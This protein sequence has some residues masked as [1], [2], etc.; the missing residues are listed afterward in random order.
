MKRWIR[1]A[2][3]LF[4]LCF[5]GSAMS[6]D[7][8][9]LAV[10]CGMEETESGSRVKAGDATICP[11][12]VSFQG[13]YIL[14][15]EVLQ[16]PLFE[17][18]AGF[19]VDDATLKSEFTL[20]ASEQIGISS[21]L[22]FVLSSISMLLWPVFG[23]VLAYKAWPYVKQIND[24]GKLAFSDNK[25]DTVRFVSY[26]TFLLVL[27]MPAGMSG[28]KNGEGYPITLGQGAAVVAALP[29]FMGGNY[30]FSTNLAAL[31]TASSDVKIN[32]AS[33]LPE[34]QAMANTMIETQLCQARTRQALMTINGKSGSEFFKDTR[35]SILF[36]GTDQDQDDI[37]K[38]Y[39]LCLGYAGIGEEE[40]ELDGLREMTINKRAP[41]APDCGH[42][43]VFSYR[44]EYKPEQHGYAH[45]C[46]KISFDMDLNKFATTLEKD[47][48]EDSLEGVLE[49]VKAVDYYRRF[50]SAFLPELRTV[51]NDT[52]LSPEKRFAEIGAAVEKASS[53][54]VRQAFAQFNGVAMDNDVRQVKFIVTTNALLGG[55]IDKGAWDRFWTSG[56]LNET[57]MPIR[58]Y[59][60]LQS[61]DER[62]LDLF[63]V[64]A[65]LNEAREVSRLMQRYQCA[66][67]WAD[68]SESRIYITKF[69]RADSEDELTEL[70]S[71]D[72][73]S[74]QC[75]E[76]L[77]EDNQGSSDLDRYARYPVLD[78]QANADI[79]QKGGGLWVVKSP[80]EFSAAQAQEVDKHMQTTVASGYYRE[81]QLKQLAL[82]G[83]LMA[84]K[85]ETAKQLSAQLDTS[86]MESRQDSELRS[87]GWGIY[88]AALLYWGQSKTSAQHMSSSIEGIL[89]VESPTTGLHYIASD[90][91][92]GEK[93][94]LEEKR[95][96]RLFTPVPVASLFV[97]G[98]I[99]TE[100]YSGPSGFSEEKAD[101]AMLEQFMG[102]LESYMMGPMD[103]IKVASGMDPD[104]TLAK[105]L[106]ACYEN[107]AGSCLS[108]SKHPLVAMSHFGNDLMDNML[109][110]MVIEASA[111]LINRVAFDINSD[112]GQITDSM[113][114][115][116]RRIKKGRGTMDK[117][118]EKGKKFAKGMGSKLKRLLTGAVA[119]FV[120]LLVAISVTIEV[121]LS[122]FSPI[123]MLL[124][125]A[126][127]FFA[128][129]VPMMAFLYS[130]MMLLLTY[131]AITVVTFVLP[132]YIILQML[133]I[134]KNYER[135]FQDF[136]EK[137]LGPYTT[138]LFFGLAAALAF[139]M[140]SVS[141]FALNTTFALLYEGVAGD[142]T[143]FSLG[144]S[145]LMLNVMMYIVYFVAL[146]VLFRWSLAIMK[147]MPD[148]M[149]EKLKL[150]TGDDSNSIDSL[151]MESYITAQTMQQ[152][153]QMPKEL[154]AA[155]AQH[156]DRKGGR[157]S[158]AEY[159]RRVAEM[160][161]LAARLNAMEAGGGGKPPPNG[162][163]QP[164]GAKRQA[165]QTPADEQ[166][167]PNDV[168]HAPDNAEAGHSAEAV[169]DAAV[170]T[171]R[172]GEEPAPSSSSADSRNTEG[173]ERGN[174]DVERDGDASSKS[175]EGGKDKGNREE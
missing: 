89:R 102:T 114:A 10:G 133:N 35:E 2:T 156:L 164:E 140:V 163:G 85:T 162:G 26:F 84:V 14:W 50:R 4:V 34:A 151:G 147:T 110:L 64:D 98:A 39:D 8:T 42:D 9:Q 83:Y 59:R 6:Q 123:I 145:G 1:L 167:G 55:T 138:P 69:N 82:A 5:A 46:G 18:W 172:P 22:Y 96:E 43:G 33:Q 76:F 165:E 52:S 51:L 143:G 90:A 148:M 104:L 77:H 171:A 174:G 168:P 81:M 79:V 11:E 152:I 175:A 131:V 62:D 154:G 94:D 115:A 23:V 142:T 3:T 38:R 32:E 93:Y 159:E 139:A 31:N 118:W 63:G 91:F 103:H 173:G 116:K 74:L 161:T 100:A 122:A 68:H 87:K 136:Y 49:S 137:F 170:D 109:T 111:K 144:L 124:F 153:G 48:V 56:E 67:E 128:F 135:G 108:G 54:T 41:F 47:G 73:A 15:G 65:L 72:G 129:V 95:L 7:E 141:M 117:V 107:G 71:S 120:A 40:D 57:V 78:S 125:A 88:G 134:E 60:G 166:L 130:L 113:E 92:G 28:G 105:G 86:R 17:E 27:M 160:E 101:E 169:G 37:I 97:P 80:S 24:T 36:L 119:V 126:G 25:G 150:K 99:G 158:A 66:L 155:L 13:F 112:V 132:F 16:D 61:D 45:R 53:S 29:A 127:A 44:A 121:V 106:E 149:K 58:Q 75:V 20:F 30:I 21:M 19:F 12:D 70:L 146:F 157:G